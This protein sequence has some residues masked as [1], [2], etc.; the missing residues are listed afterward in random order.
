[1][2][3]S[4][5]LI[6]VLALSSCA[7]TKEVAG[8]VIGVINPWKDQN[9]IADTCGSENQQHLIGHHISEF[10]ADTQKGPVR[11]LG[12]NDIYT[13]DYRPE[14]LNIFLD[15]EGNIVNLYCQ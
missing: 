11:V 1:M 10:D 8:D 6:A 5:L 3:T 14:R 7:K 2:K 13:E 9:T 12:M 4:V 15:D